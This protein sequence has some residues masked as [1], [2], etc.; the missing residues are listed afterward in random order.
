[1]RMLVKLV[2]SSWRVAEKAD[3]NAVKSDARLDFGLWED[4]AQLFAGP[5][6]ALIKFGFP[7]VTIKVDGHE[8]NIC[9]AVLLSLGPGCS[10]VA[11][12]RSPVGTSTPQ[13][14]V[15]IAA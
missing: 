13:G 9:L 14:A 6:N 12:I 15:S 11:F 2:M 10:V 7:W 5:R 1:M 3:V 8:I 4:P